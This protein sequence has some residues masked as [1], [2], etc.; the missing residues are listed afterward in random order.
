RKKDIIY[1]I[2]FSVLAGIIAQLL[3]YL[4]SYVF[5]YRDAI[6]R[7]EKAREFFDASNP[8]FFSHLGTVWLP[9]THLLMA[10]LASLD[11][12]WH[13]GLAGSIIG[14]ICF[15]SNIFFIYL[16]LRRYIDH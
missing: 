5:N 13:T 16:I 4:N 9:V 6:F 2:I 1:V 7:L 10:Q 14:Y 3:S 8:G 12:L 11:F 15:V